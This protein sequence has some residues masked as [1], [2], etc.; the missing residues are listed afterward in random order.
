MHHGSPIARP[1]ALALY[2]ILGL[3][4]AT[5]CFT[6]PGAPIGS[7]GEVSGGSTGATTTGET[8]PTTAGPTT[9][10]GTATGETTGDDP[11][12]GAMPNVC[13]DSKVDP[14]EECDN[15]D[16]NNGQNGSICKGD[17]TKNVCGDGYLAVNEGCDDANQIDDDQCSNT[18]KLAG[19]GNGVAEPGEQCDDGNTV[20]DD[21][22]SNL[23]KAPFC[24]DANLGA[25]EECDE[26]DS[27]GN[28]QVCTFQCKLAVCGDG[29]LHAGVETCDDGNQIDGDGCS[30]TC[31]A[32][33]C[34]DGVKQEGEDCDD[35]NQVEGDGCSSACQASCGNGVLDPGEE[36]DDGDI[37]SGD[38]CGPS[39]ERVAYRVF[40][41][42]QR[43]EGDLGGLLG[44][45]S[46]CNELAM[47]SKLA[48]TYLAW[49]STTKDGPAA[50]FAKTPLAYRLVTGS[51]IANNWAD[52]ITKSLLAPI[53]VTETGLSLAGGNL[54]CRNADKLVWT[55]TLASGQP[56][57]GAHCVEWTNGQ[58]AL[59]G[60]GGNLLTINS[61]WTEGC[62]VNC[63]S[64]ARLY[65]FEQP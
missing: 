21:A 42:S 41:T 26:G 29:L 54:D 60:S 44:A 12:T 1:A 23:C 48:G 6:D 11:T 38:F 49:L 10:P 50:R 39:C 36:C 33:A 62:S 19:C 52:L 25:G 8:G 13:G 16:A 40:V 30:S 57:P 20:D 59:K 46:T 53:N 27:N 37:M 34:G 51:K 14:G 7:A 15:G 31:Q 2:F 56:G 9:A 4:A 47:A 18:C 64:K 58:L 43:F 28:D 24:G 63:G 55:S 17:C 5:G 3:G 32:P 65:C 35:G 45:D 22:C 61:I